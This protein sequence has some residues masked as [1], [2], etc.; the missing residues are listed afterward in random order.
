MCARRCCGSRALRVS[1]RCACPSGRCHDKV[2]L[3]SLLDASSS[4][5][6]KRLRTRGKRPVMGR[7]SGDVPDVAVRDFA[8][9]ASA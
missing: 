5:S 1:G 9:L 8:G 2:Q 6:P 4:F 3:A 7:G